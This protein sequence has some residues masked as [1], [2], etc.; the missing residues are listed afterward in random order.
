MHRLWLGLLNVAV[1]VIH[2]T[3]AAVLTYY[4]AVAPLGEM[5]GELRMA[6]AAPALTSWEWWI[7]VAKVALAVMAVFLLVVGIYTGARYLSLGFS[8]SGKWGLS[9]LLRKESSEKYIE[10]IPLFDRVNH[11]MLVIGFLLALFTGYTLYFADNGYVYNFL[12]IGGRDVLANLHVIGGYIIF[13]AVTL[14][15]ARYFTLFLLYAVDLGIWRAIDKFPLL[16]LIPS[17]PFQ[18]LDYYLWLFFI[19]KEHGKYHKYLPTQTL[20]YYA[21]GAF[22][23]ISGATGMSM[24]LYGMQSLD[25]LAWWVHLYSTLFL[26]ILIAFHVFMT[27]IRPEYFPLDPVLITGKVH[28]EAAKEEWP[29]WV[30]ELRGGKA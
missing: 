1:G 18:L 15:I 25:G 28:E 10:R 3:L 8:H 12:Y 16:K 24:A 6:P 17:L 29:L 4:V 2:W 9:L 26:T 7:P 19:K 11:M 21:I 27:S 30:D 13:F 20:A 23:I 5:I 14:H 22:L